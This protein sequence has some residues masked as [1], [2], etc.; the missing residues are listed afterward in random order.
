METSKQI[1]KKVEKNQEFLEKY[2]QFTYGYINEYI[3][4]LK[5]QAAELVGKKKK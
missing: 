5:A 3:H 1:L 4:K 2:P